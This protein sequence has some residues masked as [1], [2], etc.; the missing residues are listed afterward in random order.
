[1]SYS[2]STY[3]SKSTLTTLSLETSL[4]VGKTLVATMAFPKISP[5][6][7]EDEPRG[8]YVL[9]SQMP[10]PHHQLLLGPP[11]QDSACSMHWAMAVSYITS[12]M[13]NEVFL[14]TGF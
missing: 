10:P 13:L 14:S 4:C 2:F 12:T 5:T 1:M 11:L 8:R 3:E 9:G 7:K 6:F